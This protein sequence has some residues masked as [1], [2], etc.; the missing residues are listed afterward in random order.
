L[1]LTG[2]RRQREKPRKVRTWP[3]KSAWDRFNMKGTFLSEVTQLHPNSSRS[4]EFLHTASL[5]GFRN[6]PMTSVQ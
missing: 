6:L 4:L 3:S 5:S 1:S 2:A